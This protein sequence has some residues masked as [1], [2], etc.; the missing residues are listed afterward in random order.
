MRPVPPLRSGQVLL[1]EAEH[2]LHNRNASVATLRTLFAFGPEC[3]SRSYR[4]QRSPSPESSFKTMSAVIVEMF[5]INGAIFMVTEQSVNGL[6]VVVFVN[7][8]GFSGLIA[9]E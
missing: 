8:S 7:P 6:Q 9:T 1:D 5:A 4:K 3:R 2:F